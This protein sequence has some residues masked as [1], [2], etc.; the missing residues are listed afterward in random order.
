MKKIFT[1]IV[2]TLVFFSSCSEDEEEIWQ[3]AK[4]TV[5]AYMAAENSLS[6]YAQSDINEMIQGVK[7]ISKYE[8]N[9]VIVF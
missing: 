5:I 2:T 6:G 9:H 1:L 8:N 4:R 7:T 3:P